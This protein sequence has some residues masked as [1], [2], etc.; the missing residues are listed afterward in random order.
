MNLLGPDRVRAVEQLCFCFRLP[1]RSGPDAEQPE[2]SGLFS[3][4]LPQAPSV[5]QEQMS[6]TEV[7]LPLLVGLN[8]FSQLYLLRASW[9]VLAGSHAVHKYA[10]TCVLTGF[11]VL[12][13]P[14]CQ[15]SAV[16]PQHLEQVPSTSLVTD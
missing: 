12:T 7:G 16:A 3:G 13:V 4:C 9:G 1:L 2:S 5:S 8:Q 15:G 14:P 6:P 11:P 10:L